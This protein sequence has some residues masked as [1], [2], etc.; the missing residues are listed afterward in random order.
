MIL[1]R[2]VLTALSMTVMAAAAGTAMASDYPSRPI[3]VVVPYAAGGTIDAMARVLSPKLQ[4]ILGQPV[5]VDNR[6][7]AGTMIGA[8]AVARA[9]PDGYTIFMGSNA[10]FTISPQVMGKV[11]YDPIRSFAAV[12]TLASFPNL[13][14]VKPDS[15][16]KTL[17]DVVQAAK[18]GENISYA[19]F[20]VGSTAQLSGEA[21][22]VSAGVNI[23]EIPYKSGAQCVQ[24]VLAGEV[25]YGF[26]TAIGAVSR[27]KQGQLRALAVTS[28]TRL[29]DLPNVPTVVEA[30]YPSAEVIA[31]VGVFLPAATPAPIQGKLATAMQRVMDDPEVKSQFAKLGVEVKFVDGEATM[32]MMRQ[33]YIRFGKLV[34]AAKI[35]AN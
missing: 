7:G 25:S 6:P 34:E 20:G 9:E 17:G 15:P 35:R 1:F 26:D 3:K 14:L 29:P 10:A 13:I 11:P 16:Y 18:K 24:A 22:K 30:G 12:G 33:E 31:W 2:K 28:A 23:T 32:R 21:I 5:V 27:V 19:S 8:D 4:A